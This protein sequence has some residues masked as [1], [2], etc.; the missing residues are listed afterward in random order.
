[1]SRGVLAIFGPTQLSSLEMLTSITNFYQVPYISWSYLD[2]FKTSRRSLT[3]GTSGRSINRPEAFKILKKRSLKRQSNRQQQQQ[4]HHHEPDDEED[5]D[6]YEYE[7]S[8]YYEN[9][10]IITQTNPYPDSRSGDA[11]YQLYLRPDLTPALISIINFYEWPRIYY[12]Y[13]YQQ[14]N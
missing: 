5:E 12:I 6:E 3:S 4:Q 10:E 1:M 9:P 7:H 13:N 8:D 11:V 14:G 2:R